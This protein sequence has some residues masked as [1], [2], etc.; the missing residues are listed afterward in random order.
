MASK[1]VMCKKAQNY[2]F[3]LNTSSGHQRQTEA[4]CNN[5]YREVDSWQVVQ[6]SSSCSSSSS[7]S[8]IARESTTSAVFLAIT[9]KY[10]STCFIIVKVL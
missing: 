1:L 4:N 8:E 3:V 7:C 6:E 5:I 10:F 2:G 9:K